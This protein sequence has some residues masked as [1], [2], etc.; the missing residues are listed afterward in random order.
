MGNVKHLVDVKVEHAQEAERVALRAVDLDAA[1]E[2]VLLAPLKDELGE[3]VK[4]KEIRVLPEK[5]AEEPLEGD[6]VDVEGRRKEVKVDVDER[7]R[8]RARG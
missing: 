8:G 7:G 2:A 5:L 6:Q 4:I 3:W 1:A